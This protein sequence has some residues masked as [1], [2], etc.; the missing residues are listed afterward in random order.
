MN[1]QIRYPLF[2]RLLIP[3]CLFIYAVT[4]TIPA[5][6]QE[7]PP[8]PITVTVV[9]EQ[10]LSFG[11]IIQNGNYGTVIVSPLGGRTATGSVIIPPIFSTVSPALF[12]IISIP[13]TLITISYDTSPQLLGVGGFLD[14]VLGESSTGSPF[15]TRYESTDVYIGGTLIVGPLT[16]NPAGAY[17][18]TFSVTFNQQ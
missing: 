7:Q 14:L 17:S 4:F 8:K 2:R 16:A 18:G 3:F 5:V 11:T 9:N 12:R 15:I 6:A 10:P 1:S 13:G